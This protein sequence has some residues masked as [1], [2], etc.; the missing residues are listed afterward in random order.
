MNTNVVVSE[1][2]K[3]NK[4]RLHWS[5]L[6]WIGGLHLG[7]L[8]APFTFSWSGLAVCAFLSVLTG[9]GVTLCYHRLLTH[10]SFQT[11]KLVEYFLT[12][13]G[14][15]ANEGGPIKWVATHRKHHAFADQE[16]DPH[17]PLKGFWWAHMGWWFRYDPVIDDPVLGIQNVK[18]LV[19]DPVHRFFERWQ[20]LPLVL[21]GGALYGLGSIWGLGWSWLVWG[22]FVRTVFILHATWLVNSAAHIWG[23][24]SYATRDRSTNLWWVAILSLGEGWHNNHHAYQR[25]ARHGLRWWEVDF[26]YAV[27]CM[28]GV[29]GLAWDIHVAPMRATEQRGKRLPW[30]TLFPSKARAAA[31]HAL[32][33]S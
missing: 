22:M 10:R 24:R 30:R 9:L 4:Q 27:I 11:Y 23:Y 21:M 13:L 7:V 3:S 17:S 6:I 28:L 1:P 26:T 12:L 2:I 19:R 16:G 18:D 8:L 25:S 14:V 15:L 31:L 5:S 20:V 29:L 33:K 32:L